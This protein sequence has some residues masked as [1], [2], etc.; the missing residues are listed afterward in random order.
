[1]VKVLFVCLG[2]I[3]RSPMAQFV[4]QDKID[5]AGL[6]DKVMVDSAATSTEALGC[7]IHPGSRAK[8][9]EMGIPYDR[10]VARQITQE[11]YD[12]YDYIIGMD[13]S[14]ERNLINFYNCDPSGKISM[15]LDFT[16][17]PGAIADPWYTG[18]FD[19]TYDDV[20]RGCDALLTY[21]QDKI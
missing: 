21:L 20:N 14:N 11:D 1:M 18:N 9:D 6:S 19:E 3:C 4:L 5:K 8:M 17:K 15:L 16:D 10:H 13:D 7:N 2:N 12:T